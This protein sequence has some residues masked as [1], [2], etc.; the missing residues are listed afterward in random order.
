M[1]D[2][3]CNLFKQFFGNMKAQKINYQNNEN[4]QKVGKSS[5]FSTQKFQ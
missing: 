5:N 1:Q 2:Q 4:W 3:L